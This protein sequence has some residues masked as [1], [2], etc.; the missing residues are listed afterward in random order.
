LPVPAPAT[1]EILRGLPVYD[2]GQERELVTPTGA[3]IIATLAARFGPLPP[4]RVSNIGYGAGT[5]VLSGRPNLLRV[6][7]GHAA[8]EDAAAADEK[9]V[10]V[11][12][13]IDDMNPELFGHLMDKLFADGALD[14]VWIPVHMKKN[15]PGTLVQVLCTPERRDGIATCIFEE[16]TSLGVRFHDVQRRALARRAVM[17]QTEFGRIKAKAVTD[18][19]GR[20]RIVPEFEVCRQIAQARGIPL[21]DV[22]ESIRH[23]ARPID[24]H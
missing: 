16:T 5:H 10:M 6:L 13:A 22:Y 19:H 23:D 21:R 4:M 11:E 14:V 20:Q 1:L 3:A 9:L 8:E 12:T 24:E 7:M 2:G 17:V 18:P 15:R